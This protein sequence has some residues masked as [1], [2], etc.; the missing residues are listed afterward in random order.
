[1]IHIPHLPDGGQALLVNHPNLT[2]RQANLG[3]GAFLGHE[4]RRCTGGPDQLPAP[5]W[6]QFDIV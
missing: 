1:V 6:L 4:L 5:A 2:A 3:I